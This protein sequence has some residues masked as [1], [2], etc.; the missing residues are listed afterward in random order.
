MEKLHIQPS[1]I[2][3]LPFYEYEYTLQ[4]YN[5]ILVE[6][7]EVNDKNTQESSNKYNVSSKHKQATRSLKTGKPKI[8]KL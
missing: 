7:K 5:E 2:D 6:R 4:F 1:E 8:P 3:A